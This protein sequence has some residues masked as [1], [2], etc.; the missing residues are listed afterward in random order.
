MLYFLSWVA[1]QRDDPH[2]SETF[3]SW[4]SEAYWRNEFADLRRQIPRMEDEIRFWR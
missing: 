2:F 3:P 1:M 4:G